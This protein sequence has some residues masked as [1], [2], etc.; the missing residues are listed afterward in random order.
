L[1]GF[2]IHIFNFIWQPIVIFLKY[3]IVAR[4]TVIRRESEGTNAKDDQDDLQC[5]GI[6]AEEVVLED[7]TPGTGSAGNLLKTF[8]F[9]HFIMTQKV[10]NSKAKGASTVL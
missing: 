6:C 1:Y 2:A 4:L 5:R 7:E 8:Y 10:R 3:G 9:C